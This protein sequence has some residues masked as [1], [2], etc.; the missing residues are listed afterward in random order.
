MSDCFYI[1]DIIEE[2]RAVWTYT[3]DLYHIS[4]NSFFWIESLLKI[5][6][7]KL[8]YIDIRWFL[9]NGENWDNTCLADKSTV[10]KPF[11]KQ[12]TA[13]FTV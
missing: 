12:K 6:A 1:L 9:E 4:E 5:R 7:L 11:R 13:I 3:I 10:A 8:S 2:T